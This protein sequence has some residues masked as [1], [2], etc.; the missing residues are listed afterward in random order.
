[1]GFKRNTSR[2]TPMSPGWMNSHER[3]QRLSSADHSRLLNKCLNTHGTLPTSICP[4]CARISL[5]MTLT[6]RKYA[7]KTVSFVYYY[8][9]LTGRFALFRAPP[10]RRFRNLTL[11]PY[12]CRLTTRQ[13]SPFLY[14]YK[15]TRWLADPLTRLLRYP[16]NRTGA[17]HVRR[18]MALR[19]CRG[20]GSRL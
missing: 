14:A 1:M 19:D 9:P 17:A 4:K 13:K 18:R 16:T 3:N 7:L 6:T 20:E 11:D 10:G 12:F 2:V 5:K 15:Q 8:R